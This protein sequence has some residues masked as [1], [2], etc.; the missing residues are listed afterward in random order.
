MNGIT[1]LPESI[2]AYLCV[3]Q[4][5]W[6]QRLI[7]WAYGVMSEKGLPVMGNRNKPDSALQLLN[8]SSFYLS[9]FNTP[10]WVEHTKTRTTYLRISEICFIGPQRFYAVF[11]KVENDFNL[12]FNLFLIYRQEVSS[13]RDGPV[14]VGRCAGAVRWKWFFLGSVGDFSMLWPCRQSE[15]LVIKWRHINSWNVSRYQSVQ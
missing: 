9:A 6:S 1:R 5:S 3:C 10:R 4:C 2:S 11:K 12:P 13:E 7:R 14:T 8:Y 15:P